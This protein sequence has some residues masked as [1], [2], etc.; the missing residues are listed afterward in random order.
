MKMLSGEAKTL[1]EMSL[2]GRKNI[3][4][5][6]MFLNTYDMSCSIETS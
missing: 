6:R 3:K 5:I 1:S 2:S 4:S